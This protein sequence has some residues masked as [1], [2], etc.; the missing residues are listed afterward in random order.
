MCKFIRIY[1]VNNKDVLAFTKIM[2]KSLSPNGRMNIKSF[3][4]V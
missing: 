4:T 1:T 3:L 2:R